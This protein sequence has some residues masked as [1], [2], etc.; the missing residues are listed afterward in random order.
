MWLWES[1]FRQTNI[2]Q[3]VNVSFF[4]SLGVMFP[5]EKYG[6]ALKKMSE[7]KNVATNF[8]HSLV[9]VDGVKQIATFTNDDTGKQ[10]SRY[11]DFLHVTPHMSPP[12]FIQKSPLADSTGYVEVNINTLQHKRYANVFS[13]GDCAALPTS[14]TAAA[15]SS[16][17]P[18]LVSNVL[19]ALKGEPLTAS[20]D[21]YTSCPI[22][23]GDNKLILAE[24]LYGGKVDESFGW[25]VDQAI[26]S[27]IMFHVKRDFFPWV[28]WN[29][30][31]KGSWYGR[32]LFMEPK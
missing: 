31:V 8:K 24:F 9:Q 27:R 7:E 5:V 14:K 13:L 16:Q 25:L 11:F 18:V 15:V 10:I 20:Y 17:A 29:H 6:N 21:G 26:P 1:V 30:F 32:H 3:D 12:D 22:L 2:R 19:K 4:T 28:Y 23:V